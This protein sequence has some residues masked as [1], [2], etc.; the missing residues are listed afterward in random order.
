M[1]P[2]A[3]ANGNGKGSSKTRYWISFDLGLGGNYR[4]I[5]EWLDEL[6]A[7]ECG[8]GL[9]TFLSPLSADEI[10]AKVLRLLSKHERA[11]AYLLSKQDGGKYAGKF[12][13]GR[14]KAAPWSGFAVQK[15]GLAES[16][17]ED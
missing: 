4:S 6:D 14:R 9:A 1:A 3:K 17:D 8:F 15:S 12:V 5:Y 2:R 11:R 10:T 7:G 13:L 16:M